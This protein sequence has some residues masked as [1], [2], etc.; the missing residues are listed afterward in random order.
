M[1]EPSRIARASTNLENARGFRSVLRSALAGVAGRS[2]ALS[3]IS[4]S[5]AVLFCATT[6][7]T[8]E[9]TPTWA[10][11]RSS[12]PSARSRRAKRARRRAE[13]RRRDERRSE[14]RTSDERSSD[15]RADT[16]RR[17][18]NRGGEG[19]AETT[20]SGGE[21]DAPATSGDVGA[22]SEVLEEGGSKVKA[23]RFTGLD[24][25][26]R[27]KSPQLLYFLNRLRAE[28]DRPRLPHRSFIPELERSSHSKS[29]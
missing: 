11:E 28:F 27:L 7:A 26:G 18:E 6:T 8:L 16:E 10:Q 20:A 19:R 14:G 15:E 24:V 1:R 13:S 2:V 12:A 23:I 22:R 25:S 17:A 21:P 3:A 4:L 9:P 5:L 29:F